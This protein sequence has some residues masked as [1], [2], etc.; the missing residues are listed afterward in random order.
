MDIKEMMA[1]AAARN[2][3]RREGVEAAL[4][5][6]PAAPAKP[7]LRVYAGQLVTEAMIK[8]ALG[9]ETFAQK[10]A[11]WAESKREAYVDGGA[12][13]HCNGTGRYRF[14]TDA[15][16]NEKCYRCDGKGRI[17]QKDLAYLDRRIKGAGPVCWVVAAPAA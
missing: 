12:C 9:L 4:K 5:V 1:A 11:R 13:P 10:L 3:A 15:T 14:H 8:V 6:A 2:K 16:R 17:N 7:R